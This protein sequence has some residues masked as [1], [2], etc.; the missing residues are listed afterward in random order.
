M[1]SIYSGCGT[2]YLDVI[3]LFDGSAN[4]RAWDFSDMREWVKTV[5]GQ[6]GGSI[7]AGVTWISLAVAGSGDSKCVSSTSSDDLKVLFQSEITIRT[8]VF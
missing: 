2:G 6:I 1:S 4:V 8:S 7:T 5:F 3:V